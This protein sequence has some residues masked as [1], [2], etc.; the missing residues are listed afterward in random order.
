MLGRKHNRKGW[1]GADLRTLLD[2]LHKRRGDKQGRLVN[3]GCR[4]AALSEILREIKLNIW[5]KVFFRRYVR[6]LKE[7]EWNHFKFK[8]SR[9]TLKRAA[10]SERAVPCPDV[11]R[12]VSAVRPSGGKTAAARLRAGLR[13][14]QHR[15]GLNEDFT[16]LFAISNL[17]NA[18]ILIAVII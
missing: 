3:K 18:V 12:W 17:S 10:E 14:L 15:E 5:I 6:S 7:R 16:Y 2:W 4:A 1:G 11:A 8:Y 9:R 13:A